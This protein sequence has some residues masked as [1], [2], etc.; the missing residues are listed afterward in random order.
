M[1]AW[2]IQFTHVGSRELSWNSDSL[3]S[4]VV[5]DEYVISHPIAAIP[6]QD[7]SGRIGWQFVMELPDADREALKKHPESVDIQVKHLNPKDEWEI[8]RF[9]SDGML[10]AIE[11]IEL[12][13]EKN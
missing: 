8:Y 7:L 4:I 3:P 13:I 12:A 2:A 1:N 11:S 6:F 9:P 5:G 10:E